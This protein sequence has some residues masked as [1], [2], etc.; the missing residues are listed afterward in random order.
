MEARKVDI[1]AVTALVDALERDLA[2]LKAGS[3]DVDALRR[4][5]DALRAALDPGRRPARCRNGC[6]ACAARWSRARTSCGRTP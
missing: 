3:G 5:V 4:E 6:T 1:E 2:R